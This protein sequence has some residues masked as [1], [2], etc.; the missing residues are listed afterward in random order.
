[1][2]NQS[3]NQGTVAATAQR[4]TS[5]LISSIGRA[6]GI[7]SGR[8]VP[9]DQTTGATYWSPFGSVVV[10][11]MIAG[12]GSAETEE[13]SV[14]HV[15]IRFHP[16]WWICQQGYR[17]L[18]TK[19]YGRWQYS[20]RSYRIITLDDPVYRACASGDLETVKRLCGQG[21]ATPFDTGSAGWSLLH[22]RTHFSH[23]MF[24]CLPSTLDSS[25]H[26]QS[27]ALPLVN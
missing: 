3:A 22:V 16:A 1:M 7:R 18:S 21:R 5:T 27:C 24:R 26:C 2:L 23:S 11:S 4:N 14:E 9:Y 8:T 10:R 6:F 12:K 20:F 17:V 13:E 19:L 15:D 25:R